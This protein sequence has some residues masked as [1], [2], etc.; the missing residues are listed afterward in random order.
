MEWAIGIF[1]V[2]LTGLILLFSVKSW[3]LSHGRLMA[4]PI[5]RSLDQRAQA[6]NTRFLRLVSVLDNFPT[7]FWYVVRYILH[8][9]AVASARHTG[10]RTS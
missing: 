4:A 5:R 8:V 9:L 2:S 3:E 10:L 7:H 1:V 6:I